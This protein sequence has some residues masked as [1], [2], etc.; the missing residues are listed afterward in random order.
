M[1]DNTFFLLIQ[2]HTIQSAF[3]PYFL[4]N[5]LLISYSMPERIKRI[6]KKIYS[7]SFLV[8]DL[9][10]KVHKKRIWPLKEFICKDLFFIAHISCTICGNGK[11]EEKKKYLGFLCHWL[12]QHC[13]SQIGPLISFYLFISKI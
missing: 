2:V 8:L 12:N 11:F 1:Q 9:R 3:G 6:E 7:R 10:E 4:Y 5:N 13:I